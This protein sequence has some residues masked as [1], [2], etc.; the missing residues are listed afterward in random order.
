MPEAYSNNMG[1][2]VA[3]GLCLYRW[4][5]RR[6]SDTYGQFNPIKNTP[7]RHDI[8]LVDERHQYFG[9]FNRSDEL[10][11]ILQISHGA[12]SQRKLSRHRLPGIPGTIS[13]DFMSPFSLGTTYYSAHHL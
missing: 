7:H 2:M 5:F 8:D 11:V 12:C 13:T 1:R 9:A 10:C 3:F 4:R 6:H